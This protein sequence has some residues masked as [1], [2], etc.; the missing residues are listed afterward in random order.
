LSGVN[1]VFYHGTCYSP[2]EAPWPGWL[3]YASYE[4]NPRNP[5]WR[6]V[7]ALNAS[8]ARCQSV[9]QSGAPDADVL[10]YWPIH[11]FW[12]RTGSLEQKFTVHA[13]DW[14][15]EQPFGRAAERL[16]QSGFDFD[17]VSDRQLGTARVANGRLRLPGGDYRVVVVPRC[18]LLPLD[19][20]RGLLA[21]ATSG[22]TIVFEEA[23][24]TDVPGWGRLDQRRQEFKTLLAR[25]TLASLGDSGLQATD[26][27][28][29]RVLVGRI[30]DALAATGI[31]REPL[32]D[33]AGL[34][35][36]RRRSADGWRYFLANRGETTFDGWL[37][38]ARP[39]ASVVVMDPMTGRT[40]RGR[41][42][43][44][45]GGSPVSVS[46]RLHPGESVILRAFERALPQEGP[47]WQVLDPAGAASDITGEWTVRFLEG[48]PEL[49][50]AITTGHPGSWTDLGDDDAQRFAGTAV[51][52]VRF[53]A[54]R[55]TA[56]HDR[57][58]LDL[59]W[60]QSVSS[61]GGIYVEKDSN[62]NT[63]DTQTAVFDFGNLQVV[64][65]HRTYGD[66][67][68]PDYP[69]SATL[70]GDKGTLKASVFK[71][72]YFERGK[73]EPALT[74]EALY[75]Y[76]QY[77]EDRTEKDLERHVASAMRRHWQNYLH[78]VDTRTRP[79]ADIE[80]AFISSASCILANMSVELGG[81]TLRYNPETG[82]VSG[83]R[84]A[85]EL[86][87]RPY[88]APWTHPTPE[89]V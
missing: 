34:W 50:A 2:D 16:W 65:K 3:F 52:S 41:L 45:V 10:L 47:A 53:D 60:P 46:L 12:Q 86:L 35:F 38:L 74:G 89:T 15:E 81:R 88:R 7:P 36:A 58:M 21:L 87:A 1:H 51:Y 48:G 29:G 33:H 39:S 71:Y 44:P 55:A 49:P 54:P 76:D 22:A 30:L 24:P 20:L 83:G 5:V 62:A 82:R 42:R 80:Q 75:E 56:G 27:G 11:E 63:T 73:K 31:D 85:N 43:T 84:Q 78:C 23:L 19:T 28:R 61:T 14:L 37:P 6:D 4:M 8:I 32:V 40:G 13:R 59:G 72:E 69:W 25:I 77:P 79:V 67:P 70:Y 64:W 57:W 68:D 66:S 26:L 9:L 17:Y 18:R